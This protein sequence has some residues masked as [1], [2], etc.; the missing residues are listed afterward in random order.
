M[1]DHDDTVAPRVA[2]RAA[3][4]T[5]S[6]T[7]QTADLVHSR[8]RGESGTSGEA[9]IDLEHAGCTRGVHPYLNVEGPSAPSTFTVSTHTSV[10]ADRVT[11]CGFTMT[12]KLI[13]W[14]PR[15]AGPVLG[16]GTPSLCRNSMSTS[17]SRQRATISAR[18]SRICTPGSASAHT[19]TGSWST[20]GTVA[21]IRYGR[22]QERSR[23]CP[24]R[25]SHTPNGTCQV[26]TRCP[27]V[28][29]RCDH[30]IARLAQRHDLP[31]RARP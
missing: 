4:I 5:E 13:P 14:C 17:L 10:T 24:R 9:R 6:L 22:S 20:K 30:P 7:Q 12:G 8:R 28:D 16:T 11:H 3:G 21:L 27:A 23:D 15:V 26:E 25:T 29:V 31:S 18:G 2:E 1:P 19:G